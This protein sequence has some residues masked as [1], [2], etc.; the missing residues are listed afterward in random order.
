MCVCLLCQECQRQPDDPWP[1][2]GQQ[3]TSSPLRR[4]AGPKQFLN[5]CVCICKCLRG[6]PRWHAHSAMISIII[7]I[8][9]VGVHIINI[10]TAIIVVG[11]LYN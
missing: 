5:Y 7:V 1:Q 3:H 9:L 8:S 2:W 11:S 10:I 4:W 6:P